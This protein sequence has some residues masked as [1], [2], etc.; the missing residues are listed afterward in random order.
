MV[1]CKL[2][3][4]CDLMLNCN[5]LLDFRCKPHLAIS[6]GFSMIVVGKTNAKMCIVY[7]N[8]LLKYSDPII[9]LNLNEL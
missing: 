6:M 3:L 7:E 9:C 4:N 1:D 5:L 8:Q 2:I